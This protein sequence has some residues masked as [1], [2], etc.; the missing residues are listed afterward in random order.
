MREKT[1]KRARVLGLFLFAFINY[2]LTFLML[3]CLIRIC[4]IDQLPFPEE[5]FTHIP[6]RRQYMLIVNVITCYF[7]ILSISFIPGII[8][9][10]YF[11]NKR[12]KERRIDRRGTLQQMIDGALQK[13]GRGSSCT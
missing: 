4:L 12:D 6:E 8:V 7:L 3:D 11:D 1:K 2:N 13:K 5:W 10:I 9:G